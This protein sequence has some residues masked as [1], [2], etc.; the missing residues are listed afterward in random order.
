MHIAI[1]IGHFFLFLSFLLESAKCQLK[2]LE[3]QQH[4]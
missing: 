2:K 4:K 1:R 3:Q